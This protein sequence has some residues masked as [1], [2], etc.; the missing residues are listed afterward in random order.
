MGQLRTPVPHPE[1]DG[2]VLAGE[3]QS[4]NQL[5]ISKYI[6]RAISPN[7]LTRKDLSLWLLSF[8]P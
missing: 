1:A 6:S 8:D 2:A 4:V 7:V 5:H 3:S